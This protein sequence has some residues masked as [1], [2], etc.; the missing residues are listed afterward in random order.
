MATNGLNLQ[1]SGLTF[2]TGTVDRMIIDASGQLVSVQL[3]RV[4]IST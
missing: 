2:A 1:T 4:Q 3:H